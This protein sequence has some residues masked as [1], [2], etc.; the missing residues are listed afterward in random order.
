MSG[1]TRGEGIAIAR[2]S[3][4]P[5]LYRRKVKIRD[6]KVMMLQGGRTHTLVKVETDG[7]VYGIGEVYGSLGGV[8]GGIVDLKNWLVGKD[9]LEMDALYTHTGHGAPNLAGTRTKDR[10]IR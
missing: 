10:R 6:I 8:K 9:P 1:L 2:L 7:C 5:L 4:P 3:F